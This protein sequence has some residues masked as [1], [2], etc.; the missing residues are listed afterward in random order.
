MTATALRHDWT[1]QEARSL[2]ELPFNDLL[3][4]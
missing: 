4:R 2:F 1:L 3:F